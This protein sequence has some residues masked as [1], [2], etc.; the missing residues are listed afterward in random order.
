MSLSGML[1][2]GPLSRVWPSCCRALRTWHL[3]I[4]A[5]LSHSEQH[6]CALWAIGFDVNF[7][8]SNQV[9]SSSHLPRRKSIPICHLA[10]S[11]P[12]PSPSVSCRSAFPASVTL[13]WSVPHHRRTVSRRSEGCNERWAPA[14]GTRSRTH[15]APGRRS[16]SADSEVILKLVR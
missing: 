5:G 2:Q 13:L 4:P 1:R 8:V 12:P 7:Q 15:T 11:A 6:T 3:W 16:R 14:R 9:L 10:P